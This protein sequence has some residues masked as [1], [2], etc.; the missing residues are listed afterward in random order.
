MPIARMERA[1]LEETLEE[2]KTLLENDCSVSV[3]VRKRR[4]VWVKSTHV[5][6]DDPT[7]YVITG[8]KQL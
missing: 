3:E 4:P 5:V 1:S 8:G 6:E 7:Y 2:V